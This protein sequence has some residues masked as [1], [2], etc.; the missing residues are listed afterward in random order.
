M[1]MPNHL[2]L[3]RHGEAEGNVARELAA[4][5]D[6]SRYTDAFVTT[7][8]R[9][10]AL[11]DKGREQAA[12]IGRWL[13]D[14]LAQPHMPERQR[15]YASPYVR[16][17]QTAAGMRL[18][19]SVPGV[20]WFLNRTLRERDWGE[21]ESIPKREF[22]AA[23][24]YALNVR[25]KLVD[26]LYWRPPGG[27][28]ICDVGENRVRNFLDTLD[29]EC[30]G[31]T[32]VAVTHGEFMWATRVVLER[33]DDETYLEWSAD[34]DAR[35]GNCEVL[36]YTRVVPEGFTH[37][38][39]RVAGWLAYRRR[40]RPVE[41]DDGATAVETGSWQQLDFTNPTDEDLERRHR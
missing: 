1:S 39:G 4:A 38:D 2:F 5:G 32:V 36:H 25:K 9:E 19:D 29:R 11:T 8:G 30:S 21:I 13:G 22:E 28:S 26:P 23:E 41:S 24:Y 20:E 40:I 7:P 37:P 18:G 33:A 14:L 3:V 31:F 17:R 27:E 16:T 10:W 35:I 34:R 12:A 6:E 15:Y